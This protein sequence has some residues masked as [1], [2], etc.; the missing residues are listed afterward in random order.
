MPF[1]PK[2]L[3]TPDNGGVVSNRGLCKAVRLCGERSH[4][5]VRFCRQTEEDD[6][7][8]VVTRRTPRGAFP[9]RTV[10]IFAKIRVKF[11]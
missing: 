5:R 8:I 4:S 3:P 2:R 7:Q 6:T 1:S 9:F 11:V 10:Y